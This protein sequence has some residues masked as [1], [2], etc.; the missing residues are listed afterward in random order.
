MKSPDYLAGLLTIEKEG[1][2]ICKNTPALLIIEREPI[3]SY[4]F[5]WHLN[6]ISTPLSSQGIHSVTGGYLNIEE[7]HEMIFV[8]NETQKEYK[9][10]VFM[11]EIALPTK[12]SKEYKL[13]FQ[14]GETLEDS[15]LA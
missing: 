11:T 4:T 10:H 3:N 1:I 2:L 6:E 7:N 15:V 5:Q 14:G 12:D 8:E 9:K 13:S